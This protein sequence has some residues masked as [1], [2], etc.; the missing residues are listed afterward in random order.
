[1][2]CSFDLT[3]RRYEV[4]GKGRVS[5]NAGFGAK[6]AKVRERACSAERQS[7][8][9]RPPSMS[10]SAILLRMTTRADFSDEEWKAMQEGITGAGM[11][12][13]LVDRGFFDSFK[14][15]NALA[16]HLRE[17]HDHSDSVLIRDLAA[18]HDRPFGATDSPEEIEQKTVATLGQAVAVLEAKSPEDLPAY[19]QLVLEVAESVAEAAKGVSPQ[20]NQ[21]LD[22]IRAAVGGG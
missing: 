21:A 13:A 7:G 18:G 1:M 15:A 4:A 19:R 10:P 14:E 9:A 8:A 17:A 22:R 3:R 12:V 6:N 11:F 16:H 20:E 5:R 2:S